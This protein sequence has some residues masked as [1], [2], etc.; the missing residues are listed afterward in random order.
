MPLQNDMPS[1]LCRNIAKNTIPAAWSWLMLGL[2]LPLAA[3]CVA[4]NQPAIR[5]TVEDPT[6]AVIA[7]AEVV[8]QDGARR[9]LARTVSDTAGAF[10]LPAAGPGKY[11][12]IA[13]K[14]GFEDVQT[15]L[16]ASSTA[17]RVRMKI[18]T[19]T[20][21]VSVGSESANKISTEVAN[22][23]NTNELDQ[24]ALDRLPVFD[25]DYIAFLSQFLDPSGVGTNGVTLVVNGVEAN[26]PG[27]TPSAIQSVKI[28]NTPYSALFSRPG[29]ARLEITTKAGTEKL[30]GTVNFLFR[31]SDFNAQNAFAATKPREQRK[32]W[33]GSLTGPITH[34]KKTTFLT[35]LNY[36]MDDLQSIVFADT[37]GGI[38]NANVPS[39]VRHFFGS[40]RI[41]H[42]FSDR[43]QFWIGYSYEFADLQRSHGFI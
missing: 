32:Y 11:F 35:S 25:Q 29:R 31:D 42:D 12:V 28:N 1:L 21:E 37:A 39:P 5:G 19:I 38:V 24:A 14:Q 36:D 40:G 9:E 41:F 30:H 26:G 16:T 23:Q 20:T 27:V 3:I 43:N 13:R 15:R 6:G 10:Q 18:A 33:E 34:D 17:L 22:N 4:Q 7:G 8:L 2:F